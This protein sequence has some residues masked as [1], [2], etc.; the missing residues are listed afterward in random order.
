[1]AKF[2]KWFGISIG[3][4]FL[5]VV[6]LGVLVVGIISKKAKENYM[7]KNMYCDDRKTVESFGNKRFAIEKGTRVDN[8]DKIIDGEK[9]YFLFDRS[10]NED[11]DYDVKSY[12]KSGSYV[13]ILGCEGYTKLNYETGEVIRS[14]NI[15]VLAKKTEKFLDLSRQ[16]RGL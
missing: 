1:M 16:A 15:E 6:I 9:R 13:Y 3:V 4:I 12:K 8:E 10:K 7:D 2:F 14:E 5:I 11:V